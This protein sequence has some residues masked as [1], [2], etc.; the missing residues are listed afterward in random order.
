M[1][2]T[3]AVFGLSGNPPATHHRNMAVELLKHFDKVLVVPC[4]PRPDKASLNDVS[5]THRAAMIDL[6]FRGLPRIEIDLSDLEHEFFTKTY[7]LERLLALQG[8]LW[9]VVGTDLV[10]GG[11]NGFAPIQKWYRGAEVWK[12]LRFAVVPRDGYQAGPEDLPPQHKLLPAVMSG[13]SSDIR[14]RVFSRRPIDGLVTPEVKA[15]IERY[16]LYH[17]HAP[18]ASV[19]FGLA[20]PKPTLVFD[21]GN[22]AAVGAA[23]KFAPVPVEEANCIVVV[24]GDGTMLRAVREHWRRRLPFFGINTGHKGCMLNDVAESIDPASFMADVT[25][26]R[27]PFLNV[28]VKP[29]DSDYWRSLLAFNDA[30]L[31][32]A[33]GQTARIAVSVNKTVRL[34][35]LFADGV[36]VATPSGSTAYAKAMGATPLP[37]R[38]PGLVLVGSNVSYP[39]DWRSSNLLIDDEVEFQVLEREKRPVRAYVDGVDCGLVTR[40]NVRVSRT[41]SAELA[42]TRANGFVS[43]L[44]AARFPKL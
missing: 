8:E 32:R 2:K 16:G 5:A 17:G 27:L 31:E 44:T 26:E 3:I 40:M 21:Q 1:S 13:A 4:G 34:P 10:M 15:Y 42:S 28:D 9:H 24:G 30:W 38:T 7:E 43:K 37:V 6:C 33:S 11:K 29:A 39:E 18:A 25:L 22:P 36:L 14:E 19:P 35:A 41:A 23:R 12:N 20:N